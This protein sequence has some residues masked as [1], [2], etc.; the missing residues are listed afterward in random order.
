[1]TISNEQVNTIF[2]YLGETRTGITEIK[3]RLDRNAEERR[4]DRNKL[5]QTL[6][7][8]QENHTDLTDRVLK[9][10]VM[11][12]RNRG[13]VKGVS[14]VMTLLVAALAWLIDLFFKI[15]SP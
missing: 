7:F 1:M 9:L 6:T 8:I 3:E 5:D 13:F 4:E 2:E 12:Q 14:F 15:K 11:E 10:E